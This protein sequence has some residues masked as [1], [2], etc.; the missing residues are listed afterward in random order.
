MAAKKQITLKMGDKQTRK[1]ML[2]A[3]E[4]GRHGDG[5]KPDVL[6]YWAEVCADCYWEHHYEVVH[7]LA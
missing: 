1:V 5:S 7:P 2:E 6:A 4:H 3:H